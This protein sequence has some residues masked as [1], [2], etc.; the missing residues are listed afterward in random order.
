MCRDSCTSVWYAFACPVCDQSCHSFWWHVTGYKTDGGP[1]DPFTVAGFAGVQ[2]E[3]CHGPGRAHAQ[4]PK[5]VD[6]VRAMPEAGCRTCHSV[7]QTGDRFVFDEYLPKVDHGA[8][9]KKSQKA[10]K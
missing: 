8:S 1:R 7:D 3:T 10:E 4:D 2:C 6:M 5:K 9:K